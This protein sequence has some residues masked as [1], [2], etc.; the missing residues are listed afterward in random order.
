MNAARRAAYQLVEEGAAEVAHSKVGSEGLHVA[1]YLILVRPGLHVD[2][3]ALRLAAIGRTSFPG[4]LEEQRH[5]S[6][7]RTEGTVVL[8]AEAAELAR[9]VQVELL[10]PDQAA[11]AEQRLTV[12]LEE[13][14]LLRSRLR[15]QKGT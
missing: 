10:R 13:L 12:A 1:N 6:V 11:A 14:R 2:D 7:G 5:Q 3:E 9:Q 4:A 15:R 8:A